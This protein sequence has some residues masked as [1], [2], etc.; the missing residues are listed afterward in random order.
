MPWGNMH[1]F[2]DRASFTAPNVDLELP[3]VNT[4]NIA[5]FAGHRAVH[6][7]ALA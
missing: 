4:E 2:R 6:A 5:A 7:L 3:D 1:S